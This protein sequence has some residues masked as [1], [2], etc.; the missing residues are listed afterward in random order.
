MFVFILCQSLQTM[1]TGK[2]TKTT[3]TW[4]CG[5]QQFTFT[6]LCSVLFEKPL[7]P[8]FFFF[9]WKETDDDDDAFIHIKKK[10]STL[11]AEYKKKTFKAHIGIMKICGFDIKLL[12]SAQSSQHHVWKS[13]AHQFHWHRETS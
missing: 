7:I 8:F 6:V 9:T 1:A 4:H 5:N 12:E 13:A 3:A 10:N 2:V 11:C